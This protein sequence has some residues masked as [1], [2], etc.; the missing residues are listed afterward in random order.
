MTNVGKRKNDV[1][2]VNKQKAINIIVHRLLFAPL[3]EKS[4]IK[5]LTWMIDVL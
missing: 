5:N 4:K 3:L 2:I 1:V